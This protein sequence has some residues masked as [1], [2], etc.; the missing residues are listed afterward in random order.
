MLIITGVG[1][2][3]T[4]L[5]A[6]FFQ[7][8]GYDLGRVVWEDKINAGMENKNVVYTNREIYTSY[9]HYGSI[10]QCL[11]RH[12]SYILN[13]AIPVVKDPRFT[14][15][16]VMETWCKL[17]SDL[18]VL[19]MFRDFKQV[20]ASRKAMGSLS[21]DTIDKREYTL[22]RLYTDFAQ[23]FNVILVY[24]VPYKLLVFPD[25]LNQPNDIVQSVIDLG[26]KLSF[27]KSLEVL[28]SLIDK[29]LIHFK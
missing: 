22:K 2:C 9:S 20:I 13:C 16:G 7:E 1:R 12:K 24:K 6:K 26:V 5:M 27:N 14:W 29:D 17:R 21:N 10:G 3:G 15:P 8:M 4:S 11:L 23:F 18:K 28:E 19:I 25:V